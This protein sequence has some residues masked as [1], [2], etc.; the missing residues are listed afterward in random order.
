MICLL[1]PEKEKEYEYQVGYVREGNS[2]KL[3]YL[4]SFTVLKNLFLI[5]SIVAMPICNAMETVHSLLYTLLDP[6]LLQ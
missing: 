4:Y 5:S 2:W 3:C 6:S 1:I